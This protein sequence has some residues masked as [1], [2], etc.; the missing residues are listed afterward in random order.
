MYREMQLNTIN[1]KNLKFFILIQNPAHLLNM[2][3]LFLYSPKPGS[4]SENELLEKS[5]KLLQ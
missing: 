2:S 5:L 3:K 1:K 4:L